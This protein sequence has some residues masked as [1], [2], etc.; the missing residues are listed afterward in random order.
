MALGASAR[1]ASEFNGTCVPGMALRTS[2]NRSVVIGL[3]DS[4]ALFATGC[5]GRMPFRKHKRIGRPLRA[6]GLKLFAECNL[7]WSQAFLAVDGGPAWSGMAATK[8]F[9]VDAL[10]AGAAVSRGQMGTD[11]KPVVIDL[12]LAGARLVAVKTIDTLLRMGRHF[13]FVND[14]VLK[15]SVALRAFSRRPN[16][17]GC[18]LRR[19]DLRTLPIDKK[20]GNNEPKCNDNSQEH[21][22]KRHALDHQELVL[23]PAGCTKLPHRNGPL[24]TLSGPPAQPQQ[25]DIEASHPPNLVFKWISRLGVTR[26]SAAQRMRHLRWL[27]RR[28]R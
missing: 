25:K 3:A 2:P 15:A 4:M 18:G 13:V 16:E 20:C 1:Q 27:Y 11:H 26:S 23:K 10:V 8:E 7:L 24:R 6:A 28:S 14:R 19:F 5:G 12:L 17:I 21:R 9:L 22:S